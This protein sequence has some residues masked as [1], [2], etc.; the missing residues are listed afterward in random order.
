MREEWL[1]EIDER[2]AEIAESANRLIRTYW[3]TA[4][5]EEA[6]RNW[7][8][9]G[10]L[11]P[12]CRIGAT[13]RAYLVW[14]EIQFINR[15]GDKGRRQKRFNEIPKGKSDSYHKGTLRRIAQNW[16]LEMVMEYEE[17]FASMRRELGYL[18]NLR[19]K[20]LEYETKGYSYAQA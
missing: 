9:W 1:E 14:C 10:K 7:K 16:E 4:K 2:M 20:I 17:V 19:R 8:E 12:R 11:S 3:Q 18:M 15:P 5:T 6:N 13:G